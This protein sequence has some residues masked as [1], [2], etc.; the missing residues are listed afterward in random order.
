MHTD[1]MAN[2]NRYT[3][4]GKEK[5]T[6]RDLGFLDFGARMLETEI[7]RWFVIDPLAEKYYSVSPYNYC[8]NNP[9][10]FID[11]DGKQISTAVRFLRNPLKFL[12]TIKLV[13][14]GSSAGVIYNHFVDGD[15]SAEVASSLIER[16]KSIDEARASS[17][18]QINYQKRQQSLSDA[19]EADI[20][21]KHNQNMKDNNSDGD[22]NGKGGKPKGGMTMKIVGGSAA[23][24]GIIEQLSNPDPSKDAHEAHIEKK[25][26]QQNNEQS[27]NT[28]ETNIFYKIITWIQNQLQ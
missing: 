11:P 16:A 8:L 14:L 23:T 7:G 15:R 25:E 28:N 19:E 6:V 26:E 18:E 13:I 20:S 22:G 17:Q 1:L 5:Q 12:R 3:F 27:H 24:I 10:K 2:T 4:S 21:T 9:L